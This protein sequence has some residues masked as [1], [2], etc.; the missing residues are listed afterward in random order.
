[1]KN[2]WYHH[3]FN[4]DN[5]ANGVDGDLDG[6]KF[7]VEIH[8]NISAND[9][10]Q[11]I[12]LDY[13]AQVVDLLKGFDNVLYEICNECVWGETGSSEEEQTDILD[14][15]KDM[16]EEVRWMERTSEKKHLVGLT[17][18]PGGN[19]GINGNPPTTPNDLFEESD[20]DWMSPGGTSLTIWPD[21]NGAKVVIIDTDHTTPAAFHDDAVGPNFVRDWTWFQFTRGY[22]VGFLLA[23]R[24]GDPD[25]TDVFSKYSKARI[26]MNRIR[27][28]LPPKEPFAAGGIDL[29]KMLPNS[30][31]CGSGYCLVD[32]DG[33]F[34][35]YWKRNDLG[36]I[37][38]EITNPGSYTK[39]WY[40]PRNDVMKPESTVQ[41]TE[42]TNGF[43]TPPPTGSHGSW[44]LRL[45][46][47]P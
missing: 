3:P 18:S 20:A 15:M 16:V 2:A 29:A 26:A 44:V 42:G 36:D 22:S 34:L 45:T 35:V 14:W 25:P 47:D 30:A 7:G 23:P 17:N 6:D 19:K 32:P 12:Q 9:S 40:D 13:A 8:T 37:T 39:Q 46:K 31:A 43:T 10:V 38:V 24:P 27:N 4:K 5:N 41:L 33:D 11:A 28:L 1:M 21:A